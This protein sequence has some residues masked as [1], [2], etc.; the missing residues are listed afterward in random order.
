MKKLFKPKTKASELSTYKLKYQNKNIEEMQK[1]FEMLQ[2]EDVKKFLAGIITGPAKRKAQDN[3]RF[4]NSFIVIFL[5]R[6]RLL[7][8]HWFCSSSES[9]GPAKIPR[10]SK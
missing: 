5:F 8:N 7:I 2:L 3:N 4:V 10:L 9:E 1:R 6:C